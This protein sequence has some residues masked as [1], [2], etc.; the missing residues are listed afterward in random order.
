MASLSLHPGVA[1]RSRYSAN[2]CRIKVG[3][4]GVSINMLFP[5]TRTSYDT[6]YPTVKMIGD[7]SISNLSVENLNR[8]TSRRG[9]CVLE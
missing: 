6:F 3:S 8:S 4:R 9:C 5:F 1:S 7:R 2:E